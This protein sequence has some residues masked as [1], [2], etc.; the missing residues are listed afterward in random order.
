M[1]ETKF[2]FQKC[3][4]DM[5]LNT[6]PFDAAMKEEIGSIVTAG[7]EE[8][9]SVQTPEIALP[10]ESAEMSPSKPLV[11]LE[12][13]EGMIPT[14]NI[15]EPTAPEL[16]DTP[17]PS[18]MTPVMPEAEKEIISPTEEVSAPETPSEPAP[19]KSGQ[20]DGI[21][22]AL[23]ELS[24][25]IGNIE[26]QS[27]TAAREMR[28]L[29]KLYHTEFAG[30]LKKMQGELDGFHEVGKGRV[31]DDIL[32]ELAKLYSNNAEAVE[33]IADEKLRKQ[34]GYMFEDL[35]QIFEQYGVSAL[36]SKAGER[37]NPM[38]CQV[39]E[40]IHTDDSTLHDTVAKSLNIG[41]YVDKR[42]LVKEMIHVNIYKAPIEN[43]QTN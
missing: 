24:G 19:D 2:Y 33:E 27:E 11:T 23:G 42:T 3:K 5:D 39:I 13:P 41:F 31:F 32:K 30:R 22:I 18:P 20:L 43:G 4:E 40:R 29:H 25:K 17:Q 37:R 38:H 28:E 21:Q 9:S 6:E 7:I 35:L 8:N 34:F 26:E 12:P 16:P 14:P 15:A 36:K 10:A 1:R